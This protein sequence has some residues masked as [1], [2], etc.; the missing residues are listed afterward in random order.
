MRLLIVSLASL[1]FA[2][3]DDQQPEDAT[4]LWSKIQAAKYRGFPRPT[5]FETRKP[6]GQ[7]H[8]E[9]VDVYFNELAATAVRSGA[10]T[11]PEGSLFVKDGY[12]NGSDL[13]V[14]TAMEKRKDGWFYV[15][16]NG[17]GESI[18]SG[19]PSVCTKCHGEGDAATRT[20]TLK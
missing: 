15:E 16:W 7:P 17:E 13:D 10:K 1:L 3:G 19:R 4:A 18:Y 5:G 12:T 8:G 6:S 2:C 20:V 14:I 11:W 9:Q